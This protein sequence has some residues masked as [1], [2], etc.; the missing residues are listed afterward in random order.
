MTTTTMT[1]MTTTMTTTMMTMTTTMTMTMT[2]TMTATTA[3]TATMR[4]KTGWPRLMHPP[5][6][7][8]GGLRPVPLDRQRRRTE[9]RARGLTLRCWSEY[10]CAVAAWPCRW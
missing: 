8:G 9:A 2:T 10:P 6:G 4:L 1:T 7:R 3:T 5:G